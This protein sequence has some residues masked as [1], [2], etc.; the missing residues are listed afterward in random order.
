MSTIYDLVNAKEISVYYNNNPSNDIPYLGATLFPSKKQLG[1]DLS[2]IKGSNGLPVALQPSAFDTKATIRDRIGFSKVETEM[3][4]FREAMRIGEKERQEINKVAG[5][6][7]ADYLMPLI[8]KIYDDANNLV[9]GAEVN[10]ERMRMQLLSTG[11][12]SIVANHVAYDYDFKFSADN[13]E[14]LL[15]TARWSDTA[16]STPV[17]DIMRWQQVVE[18]TVGEKPSRA[19]C[20]LKT[21]GYLM[22]N[23]SIRLDMNPIGGTNI[24]MTDAMLKQY[25]QAK[26]GLAVAVYNKKYALQDGTTHQ[27]FPDD[28]F[29][30]LPEGNLGNTYYGTTPEE[31]DLMS[32]GTDAVVE[33]V[34]TGVAVTTLKIPH[35]VNVETIV[36]EI[37]L[38]SFER[39][40]SVFIA[41]VHTA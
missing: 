13:Q 25:F 1:L 27:F 40:N 6:A 26:L 12:I 36:S 24:I 22:A 15:T 14:T 5:S 30:L 29:T 17:Q 39:I 35:P 19:V 8:E 41:T 20:S 34:N 11:K 7:N 2:W 21:W 38:P 23:E 33:I 32:G 3:P 4:F 10:N 9:R 28:V 37:A 31:S 16:N 18:D